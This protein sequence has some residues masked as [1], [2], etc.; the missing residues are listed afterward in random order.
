MRKSTT[1]NLAVG[2]ATRLVCDWRPCHQAAILGAI[3][4]CRGRFEAGMDYF[5]VRVIITAFLLTIMKE[6]SDVLSDFFPTLS[7]H[8]NHKK[9]QRRMLRSI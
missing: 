8:Q 6:L 2:L 7:I 9:A 5:A 3:P 4:G 1:E